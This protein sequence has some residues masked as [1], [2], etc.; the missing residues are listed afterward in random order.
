M[1]IK[2]EKLSN[3]EKQLLE[4][5]SEIWD[6]SD[7]IVGVLNSLKDDDER[8]E[9]IEFIE[10][11]DDVTSEQI[12]LLSLDISQSRENIIVDAFFKDLEETAKYL[13]DAE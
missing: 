11:N 5:L 1:K 3:T 7:F 13:K 2:M 4:L 6:D 9:I 10:N 12:V 8:K